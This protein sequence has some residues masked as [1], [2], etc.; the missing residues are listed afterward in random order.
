METIIEVFEPKQVPVR[1][2]DRI[3]FAIPK[4][5][6]AVAL[7]GKP[8]M[9]V[10]IRTEDY[11]IHAERIVLN[12]KGMPREIFEEYYL[13]GYRRTMYS[14]HEIEKVRH[15]CIAD[16]EINRLLDNKKHFKELLW[17]LKEQ[18]SLSL[19]L[20]NMVSALTKDLEEERA[21]PKGFWKQ[22]WNVITL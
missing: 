20:A 14:E 19:S 9:H 7:D 12:I 13:K 17:E 8:V 3:T 22:L 5:I 11:P 2:L 4:D 18:Q 10:P 6:P 16:K 21:K 15:F 1:N